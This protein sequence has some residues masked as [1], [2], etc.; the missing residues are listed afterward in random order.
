MSESAPDQK[1][2]GKKKGGKKDEI[3]ALTTPPTKR[4]L[5][6]NM[7]RSRCFGLSAKREIAKMPW[8]QREEKGP[9]HHRCEYP[10]CELDECGRI[11]KPEM[12]NNQ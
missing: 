1:N 5:G 6:R 11:S 7:Y 2:R 8:D 10:E 3:W 12:P 9:D 4:D